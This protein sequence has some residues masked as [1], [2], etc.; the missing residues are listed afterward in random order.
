MILNDVMIN[1]NYDQKVNTKINNIYL[2]ESNL[3]NKIYFKNIMNEII[4]AYA[5]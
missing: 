1:G 3:Q 5:G 4:E 2:R